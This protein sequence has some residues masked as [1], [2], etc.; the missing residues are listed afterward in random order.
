MFHIYNF[1][2]CEYKIIIFELFFQN[3]ELG[4]TTTHNFFWFY[5]CIYIYIH[6]SILDTCCD[7]KNRVGP[8]SFPTKHPDNCR[9]Q[10][11]HGPMH[12][13]SKGEG[14]GVTWHMAV[15]SSH[16]WWTNCW[17]SDVFFCFLW[18]HMAIWCYMDNPK[19][20]S[21]IYLMPFWCLSMWR[22]QA[23]E[24][25]PELRRPKVH[26]LSSQCFRLRMELGPSN[27][28]VERQEKTNQWLMGVDS[29]PNF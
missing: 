7:Q 8:G 16:P 24:R 26:A 21:S 5:L 19:K 10:L 13:W 9:W 22:C 14:I 28:R 15:L 18:E 2:N 12:R 29:G 27:W 25:S 11:S 3:T 23:V 17:P 4:R 20:E 1:Q 6:T